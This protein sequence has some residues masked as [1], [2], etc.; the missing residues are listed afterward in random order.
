MAWQ[1]ESP[2]VDLDL[3]FD[4][5]VDYRKKANYVKIINV[6]SVMMKTMLGP[7]DCGA[8]FT[9]EYREALEK[10]APNHI[11]NDKKLNLKPTV[12]MTAQQLNKN[13]RT[14]PPQQGRLSA[15]PNNGILLF[16]VE[17]KF[18]RTP[19]AILKAGSG[20]RN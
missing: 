1:K 20:T 7:L 18:V 12:V 5:S 19:Q 15:I 17:A 11:A 8:P 6:P 3:H 16:C 9:K 14:K 2:C 4:Q 13:E 10:S